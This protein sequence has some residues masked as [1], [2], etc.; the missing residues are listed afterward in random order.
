M[1]PFFNKW[2][3]NI[4]SHKRDFIITNYTVF[5]Y[6]TKISNHIV[7]LAYSFVRDYNM[8]N[9]EGFRKDLDKNVSEAVTIHNIY[10]ATGD[11]KGFLDNIDKYMENKHDV[12]I[13]KL[14]KKELANKYYIYNKSKKKAY[15][16]KSSYKTVYTILNEKIKLHQKFEHENDVKIYKKILD[17]HKLHVNIKDGIEE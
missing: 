6:I 13:N 11:N 1:D 2:T 8:D 5:N 3:R 9:T 16:H 7:E 17:F 4:F 12:Y 14:L 10:K 15:M